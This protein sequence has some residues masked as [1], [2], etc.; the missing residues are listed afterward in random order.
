MTL[1]SLP[2]ENIVH[3][4]TYLTLHDIRN[5]A[6]VGSY[7]LRSNLMISQCAT[8]DLWTMKMKYIFPRIFTNSGGG[9]AG[10]GITFVNNRNLPI[11]AL[12]RQDTTTTTTQL[13]QTQ[14]NEEDHA[15]NLPLLVSLMPSQYPQCIDPRTLMMEDE[16][17]DED[18]D[19]EFDVNNED[20]FLRMMF[21][22]AGIID[23]LRQQPQQQPQQQ[24]AQHGGVYNPISRQQRNPQ[25]QLQRLHPI[26]SNN[27]N[28]ESSSSL[29]N[30]NGGSSGSARLFDVYDIKVT[31]MM[32]NP[33]DN[34]TIK[35]TESSTSPPTS[36]EVVVQ[37]IQFM[38]ERVGTG[39]RCIR[40][41][42]PFPPTCRRLSSTLSSSSS[43]PLLNPLVDI[44]ERINRIDSSSSMVTDDDDESNNIV[45]S[46]GRIIMTRCK[47]TI[48]SKVNSFRKRSL[49]SLD[50]DP[51]QHHRQQPPQQKSKILCP[52]VI[53]TVISTGGSEGG[54][55]V[56]VTPRFVAYFEV[57]IVK[58]SSSSTT[59]HATALQQQQQQQQHQAVARDERLW[60]MDNNA[61][62]MNNNNN[63]NHW[64]HHEERQREG[65]EVR[66]R[67]RFNNNHGPPWLVPMMMMPMHPI[68]L[69]LVAMMNALDW[70]RPFQ[71]G[72]VGGGGRRY[73]GG[74]FVGQ[75]QDDEHQRRREQQELLRHE[76][77]RRQQRR[78]LDRW[79]ADAR[80]WRQPQNL[81]ADNDDNN[82]VLPHLS[83]HECVAIGLSTKYFSPTDKMPGW[84]DQSFG[85]HSDDGGTYHGRGDMLRRYGPTYGPGD[86]VGCGL[87]YISR[88]IFFVKNGV[89]LGYAFGNRHDGFGSN[90]DHISKSGRLSKTIVNSGLYPTVGIDSKYP[91]A[92]NFGE[93]P[94][95]FDLKGFASASLPM[96]RNSNV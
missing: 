18:E 45:S 13:Q 59:H 1:T 74:G 31:D 83:R 60:A 57:T 30:H 38:G 56:D 24:P 82:D 91:I 84:D 28:D 14:Q 34:D 64:Q 6:S 79:D 80:R 61:V 86:T 10:G 7:E 19:E 12:R 29:L 77:Q 39:D 69:E 94:F 42:F 52:F 71:L 93:R 17:N 62:N 26:L 78:G 44:V 47:R 48:L 8:V 35:T 41:N 58:L 2:I 90:S 16:D 73:T 50:N 23:R 25:R 32:L 65:R 72:V 51:I 95:R 36:Q 88:R 76:L 3:I 89:F 54:L 27:N 96:S 55:I 20:D 9:G 40:S 53:P 22:G 33:N 87:D 5:L 37:V 4:S 46:T 92:V 70:N 66:G 21:I 49:S 81:N 15:I 85:Y 63:N 75:Q 11:P 67:Q 68:P 43:S